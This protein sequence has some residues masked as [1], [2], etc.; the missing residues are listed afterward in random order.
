M[1][2]E[3]PAAEGHTPKLRRNSAETP[4]KLRGREGESGE[5]GKRVGKGGGVG[6]RVGGWEGGGNREGGRGGRGRKGGRGGGRDGGR[7]KI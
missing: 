7:V 1:A 3:I 4:P 5:G 6:D 2:A